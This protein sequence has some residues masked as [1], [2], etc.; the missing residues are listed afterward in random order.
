MDHIFSTSIYDLSVQNEGH[1]LKWIKQ[2]VITYSTDQ[3]TK[4]NK[5]F[6]IYLGNWIKLELKHILSQ[7][8]STLEYG[9]L[10]Q[11]IIVHAIPE[12]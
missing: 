11:P 8:V 1:K 10:N 3:E 6:I 4:V 9:L 2:D 7:A 5:M 12:R